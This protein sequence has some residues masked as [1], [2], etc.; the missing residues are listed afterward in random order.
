MHIEN[1]W[2]ASLMTVSLMSACRPAEEPAVA[3]AEPFVPLIMLD[4]VWAGGFGRPSR[5][6]DLRKTEGRE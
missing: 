5:G 4:S 1:K 6:C 3:P 2:F